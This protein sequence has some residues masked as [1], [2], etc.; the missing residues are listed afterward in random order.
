MQEKILQQM[1]IDSSKQT[2]NFQATLAK[3]IGV[4]DLFLCKSAFRARRELLLCYFMSSA[5]K[6]GLKFDMNRT[7]FKKLIDRA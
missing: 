7:F 5:D 3:L 2:P 6:T 1:T 4:P